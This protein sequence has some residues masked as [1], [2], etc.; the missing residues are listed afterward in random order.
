MMILNPVQLR[1]IF[2][3]VFLRALVRSVP[4]STFALKGGVN[5]RFFFGSIRYSEDM[6]IDVSGLVV[7]ALS[8]KVIKYLNRQGWRT[9]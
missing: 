2:H 1:E 6:N 8:E 7:N 5:L 3:L 4:L 9:P